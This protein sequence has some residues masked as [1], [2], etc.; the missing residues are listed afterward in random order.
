[1]ATDVVVMIR[2]LENK[3]WDAYDGQAVGTEAL[4]SCIRFFF[5]LLYNAHQQRYVGPA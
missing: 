3:W 4:I 5:L 2:F 1:M